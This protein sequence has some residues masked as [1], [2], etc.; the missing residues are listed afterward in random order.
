MTLPAYLRRDA[1][2]EVRHV[3][4]EA[5]VPPLAGV[6]TAPANEWSLSHPLHHPDPEIANEHA[7]IAVERGAQAL[8]VAVAPPRSEVHGGPVIRTAEDLAT[9]LDGIDLSETDLHLGADL[10]APGLHAL[11][12]DLL[13]AGVFDPATLN[14]S[15]AFDPV[16][17]LASGPSPGPDA[18]FR[19]AD[20]LTAEAPPHVRSVTVDA[21]VY[22]DAGASAVQELAATLAALTERLARSTDRGASLPTL[23]EE[24]Q[25]L[26]SV[27][28]SYF[29]EM[30]KL[31][32]LRL[33]VPQLASAFGDEA[34]NA[35]NFTPADLQIRAE[36]SRRTETIYD[37]YVNMLRATTEAMAAVLGGCDVLSLHPYDA[38]LR[39]PDA[40]GSRIARNTQLIL[41]HEAHFDHVA[42]PAAGSY[43]VE[44]LTDRLA[45]RAWTQFQALEAEGGIVTALRNGTLQHQIAETRRERRDAI[46]EREHILVGTTHYP[47]L[48]ERRR[49]DL[50]SADAPSPNGASEPVFDGPSLDA[51]RSTL[52]EGKTLPDVTSALRAGSTDIDPLPR[53]RLAGP[54]EAIRLRTEAYAETHDGPPHVLLAPLGPPAARSARARF[55]RN[56]LGVA[57]FSIE[58]PLTFESV[59]D[60]ADAAVEQDADV[61]V[62]CSSNAEYADLAPALTSA[63]ADRGHDALLGIAGGPDD[64]DADDHADF[65]VHQGSSLTETLPTLQ[66]HLGISTSEDA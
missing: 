8:Y 55:A 1:L 37:P 51:I 10:A 56:F 48:D 58:E 52:R 14:G 15:I 30:A 2:D 33:L 26:V 4:G 59:D 54:I 13:S 16:A 22:H 25:I 45:Q 19:L 34:Q 57:G 66:E 20:Q 36:T 18:T 62:L 27:S 60:A 64:I 44:T 61:V 17:V 35:L 32:A 29:V 47:A 5:E 28:T 53:I 31:R 38:S 23:L 63:L 3:E 41:E 46:D 50:A 40:F 21:R 6:S 42:D 24:L 43:Y 9:V 49:D 39:P 11:L 65:F 12:Q 7:R